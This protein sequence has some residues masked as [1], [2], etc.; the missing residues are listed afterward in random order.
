MSINKFGNQIGVLMTNLFNLIKT[1]QLLIQKLLNV[2][3]GAM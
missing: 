1:Q 2:T 3:L